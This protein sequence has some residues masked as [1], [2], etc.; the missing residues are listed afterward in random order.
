MISTRSSRHRGRS[1]W[2]ITGTLGNGKRVNAF[3]EDYYA[4]RRTADKMRHD[5]AY[6]IT[7][8]DFIP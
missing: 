7:E 3:F 6:Q 1:G 8:G 5:P 4:A 2:T